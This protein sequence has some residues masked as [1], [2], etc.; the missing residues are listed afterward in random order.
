VSTRIA[1]SALASLIGVVGCAGVQGA[2]ERSEAEDVEA[3]LR[4]AGFRLVAADTP[5]R[6]E[7]MRTLPPLS[8]SRVE[9]G[10]RSRYVYA[11]PDSCRCLWVGTPAQLAHYQRLA[12]EARLGTEQM[13]AG[14]VEL[15]VNLWDPEWGSI[16]DPTT[17]VIDPDLP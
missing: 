7:S 8:F 9:R 11:D 17:P 4:I 3:Q 5:A 16:D 12:A 6:I 10:G 13:I 15:E 14:D 2:M 1:V